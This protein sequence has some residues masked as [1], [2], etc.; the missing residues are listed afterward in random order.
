MLRIECVRA[1]VVLSALALAVGGC[2][3][4]SSED[5]QFEGRYVAVET[6]NK[7]KVGNDSL[8]VLDLLG[9][10]TSRSQPEPGTDIWTWKYTKATTKRGAVFLLFASTTRTTESEAIYVKLKDGKVTKTWRTSI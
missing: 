6:L 8:F 3:V 4:S 9:E 5:T 1:V 2:V 7:V 10:P